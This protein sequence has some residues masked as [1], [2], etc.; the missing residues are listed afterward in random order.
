[1]LIRSNLVALIVVHILIFN[2]DYFIINSLKLNGNKLIIMK[3]FNLAFDKIIAFS[4]IVLI[5]IIVD[6]LLSRYAG[7]S[8]KLTNSKLF[9]KMS[10]SNYF[11]YLVHQPIMLVIL[12]T[13]K[14]VPI[15]PIIFYNILFWSTILISFSLAEIYYFGIHFWQKR[16]SEHFRYQLKGR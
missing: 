12:N 2:L 1:M 14:D 16:Y 5:F 6:L 7:I 9:N 15:N 13:I 11:I 4:G 3:I 8:F 10:K